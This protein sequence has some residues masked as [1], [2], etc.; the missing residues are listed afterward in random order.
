MDNKYPPRIE[1]SE[2]MYGNWEAGDGDMGELA[3]GLYNLTAEYK[4]LWDDCTELVR[5]VVA[6]GEQLGYEDKDYR[7]WL[8]PQEALDAE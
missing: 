4:A 5:V 3:V 1:K 8:N 6:R 2:A 7:E